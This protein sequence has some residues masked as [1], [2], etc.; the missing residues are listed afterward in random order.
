MQIAQELAGYS[1]GEADLLRRAMGKKIHK[2]M[3]AQR[4]IFVSRAVDRGVSKDQARAIF[5]LIAK[6]ASYGFNKSH[7]AAYA[8]IAYQ[9]AY[10]KANY[11]VEFLAASMTLDMHNTD[12][13]SIFKE[14]AARNGIALLPPDIN[15]SEAQFSVEMTEEGQQAIRYGLAAL[16]NVGE[17]AMALLVQER[18]AN[19][20]Y[21]SL[22]DFVSRADANVLNRRQLEHMIKA[23]VFDQLNGNR[24]QLMEGIDRLIA[25]GQSV[26]R[27]RES[28]QV[29][30]FAAQEEESDAVCALPECTD[31]PSLERLQHEYS[32]V[33]FYLTSHPLCGYKDK[34]Q[35]LSVV[36]SAQFTER[37]GA[38]PSILKVAG[39][40]LGT[41]F[42][43]SERGRYAFVQLSD[44]H[45]I[46]EVSLFNEEL[47]TRYYEPLQNGA[48]LLC[49]VEG[50]KEDGGEDCR[51]VIK[52]ITLLE[53]AIHK[54]QQKQGNVLTIEIFQETPLE[55][56]RRFLG[57]ARGA[58]TRV[59]IR[60]PLER[61]KTAEV[62]LPGAY[63]PSFS[64][65]ERIRALEGIAS[66][67]EGSVAA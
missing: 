48:L 32:A 27:E 38:A 26:Q 15:A 52:D 53:S 24:R 61:G 30:L 22:Q 46:F 31:W 10:L 54:R 64:E 28:Q 51:L 7:A 12:K 29:N 21:K 44:E 35:E 3:E 20:A 11:P 23:G 6:F 67:E 49:T 65:F 1:L 16:K 42:R 9:T 59:V 13:L 8:L 36:S 40:V 45:G 55:E 60:V 43:S 63:A 17:A 19:G 50:K 47:L 25:F 34:L 66:V 18:K 5:D 39:I 62:M 37:L 4:E 33:G 57:E 41:K 56:V 2:E 14:E 58:G